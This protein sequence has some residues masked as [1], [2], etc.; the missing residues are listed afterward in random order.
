I[1][2]SLIL[3]GA[4]GL[5][6]GL[7]GVDQR[8]GEQFSFPRWFLGK[9]GGGWLGQDDRAEA[10]VSRNGEHEVVLRLY[11]DQRKDGPQTSLSIGKIDAV[12]DGQSARVHVLTVDAAKVQ[13]ALALLEQQ[14]RRN[15]TR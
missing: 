8:S 12:V 11:H 13:A 1:R 10:I 7:A 14:A 15:G 2:V 3:T 4:S 6:Q 9:S 5:P